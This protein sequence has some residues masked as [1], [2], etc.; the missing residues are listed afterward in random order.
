VEAALAGRSTVNA[1]A[2]DNP[3]SPLEGA[4]QEAPT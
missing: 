4:G 1:A 2:P 3:T